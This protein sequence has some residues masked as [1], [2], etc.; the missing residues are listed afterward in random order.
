MH[1][2]SRI[3]ILNLI[4][5][6]SNIRGQRTIFEMSSEGKL[7]LNWFPNLSIIDFCAFYLAPNIMTTMSNLIIGVDIYLT[8]KLIRLPDMNRMRAA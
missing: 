1:V 7:Y 2:I 3:L 5:E 6:V 8:T 4:R